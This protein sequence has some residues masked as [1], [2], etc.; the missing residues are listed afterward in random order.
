MTAQDIEK[1]IAESGQRV[2]EAYGW[3]YYSGWC[4]GLRKMARMLEEGK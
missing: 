3:D 4:A 1:M 2:R